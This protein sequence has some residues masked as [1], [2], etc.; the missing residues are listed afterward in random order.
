MTKSSQLVMDSVSTSPAMVRVVWPQLSMGL[1]HAVIFATSSPVHLTCCVLKT[2]FLEVIHHLWLL[3]T[4]CLL[5]HDC[6]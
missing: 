2:W 6:L 1:V 4:S 5:F 3:Q